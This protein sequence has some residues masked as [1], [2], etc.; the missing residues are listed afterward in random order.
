MFD[1]DKPEFSDLR[2]QL[3]ELMPDQKQAEAASRTTLNAHYTAAHMA[4]TMW[5]G[6]QDLGFKDGVVLEPGSGIGNFIGLAPAGA[7]MLGVEL[8]PTTAAMSKALHPNAHIEAKGFQ[9]VELKP[10][11]L[12]AVIGNVPFADTVLT[13]PTGGN[14][15]KLNMHDHFITKAMRA[16]RPGG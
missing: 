11:S 5:E 6:M 13:D 16:V 12:D 15:A 1:E 8:D 3:A 7:K 4:D 9:N 14:K 10:N 2:R